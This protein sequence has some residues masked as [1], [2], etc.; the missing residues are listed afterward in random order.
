M[1]G[2]LRLLLF[3]LP[4]LFSFSPRSA[5]AVECKLVVASRSSILEG[6]IL[7]LEYQDRFKDVEF[8]EATNG[9]YAIS[10][11]TLKMAAGSDV[12]GYVEQYGLPEDSFCM[13]TRSIAQI[14]DFKKGQQQEQSSTPGAP[15]RVAPTAGV[16]GLPTCPRGYSFE[17]YQRT[18]CIRLVVPPNAS[19]SYAGNSWACDKG[20]IRRGNQCSFV[21]VPANAHLTASVL[22]LPNDDGWTC[23]SGFRRTGDA[24][25]PI[26]VPENAQLN[27]LGNGY[28]CISGYVDVGNSC[29]RMT[30]DELLQA[31][32]RMEQYAYFVSLT[33]K[34][35]FQVVDLC[36]K[37]CRDGS[38]S[39]TRS[40]CEE[41]CEKMED[42]CD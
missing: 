2:V 35:C 31:M 34:S 3:T 17:G 15:D 7:A 25:E 38:F 21:V 11:A 30:Y 18:V 40:R 36:E 8:I 20:Y 26:F 12:S 27:Q 32:Q 28:A 16:L 14:L 33:H 42:E 5:S 13:N 39:F 23:N 9:W 19:L 41:V 22:S 24:C 6:R 37:V 4:L 1:K 10:V 29:R